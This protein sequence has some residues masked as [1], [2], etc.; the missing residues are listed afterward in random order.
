MVLCRLTFSTKIDAIWIQQFFS[1]WANSEMCYLI[2][3]QLLNTSSSSSCNSD[4]I[5]LCLFSCFTSDIWVRTEIAKFAYIFSLSTSW[6]TDQCKA[7][8]KIQGFEKWIIKYRK[9]CQDC[10][11]FCSPIVEYTVKLCRKIAR[12]V[13]CNKSNHVSLNVSFTFTPAWISFTDAKDRQL[14]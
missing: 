5:R 13:K 10:L 6:C 9:V 3:T 4:G 11:T 7:D 14:K 12:Y 2:N 8:I 1:C